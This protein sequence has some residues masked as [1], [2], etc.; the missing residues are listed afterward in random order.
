MGQATGA[1]HYLAPDAKK[2]SRCWERR[3]AFP[4]RLWYVFQTWLVRFCR[5]IPRRFHSRLRSQCV[6][7]GD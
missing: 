1:A 6:V 2:P 4:R 7:S 5:L 3:K